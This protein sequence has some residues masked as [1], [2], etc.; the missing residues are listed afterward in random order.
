MKHNLLVA[1]SNLV[2]LL[3][4]LTATQPVIQVWMSIIVIS[5]VLMHLS[6]TKHQLPGIYPF[7]RLATPL[8]WLDRVMAMTPAVLLWVERELAVQFLIDNFGLSI[9]GLLMMWLAERGVTRK[10]MFV[11][12]HSLWHG[13]AYYLC[14]RF[15]QSAHY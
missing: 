13:V 2:G 9:F 6:E 12:T 1:G 3:P 10:S 15:I 11:L 14:Y 8:L 7:N 4:I 5:S